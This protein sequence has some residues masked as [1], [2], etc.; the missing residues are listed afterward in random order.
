MMTFWPFKKKLPSVPSVDMQIRMSQQARTRRTLATE[1]L[2][3]R[4][5]Q[6]PLDKALSD[7]G[8]DLAP[9]QKPT[10]RAQE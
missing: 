4:I 10:S 3:R 8:E 5:Q 2:L 9:I 7:L 1:G 6:T